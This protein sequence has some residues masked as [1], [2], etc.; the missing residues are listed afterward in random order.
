MA[1]E[2][3]ADATE[4]VSMP[5]YESDS[6][7]SPMGRAKSWDAS[8]RVVSDDQKLDRDGCGPSF[9]WPYDLLYIDREGFEQA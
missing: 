9:C 5:T 4:A 7:P 6:S 8:R 1:M 2:G 3:V